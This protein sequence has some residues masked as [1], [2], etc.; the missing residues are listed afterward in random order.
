V[1][2]A[3]RTEL[4]PG[5]HGQRFTYTAIIHGDRKPYNNFQKNIYLF[6]QML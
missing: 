4:D 1:Y 3:N 5:K 6:V 2:A